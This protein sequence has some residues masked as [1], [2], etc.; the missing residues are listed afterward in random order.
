M[1][2]APEATKTPCLTYQIW[3]IVQTPLKGEELYTQL[4]F[5]LFRQVLTIDISVVESSCE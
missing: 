5:F 1:I 2:V 4:V 3:I